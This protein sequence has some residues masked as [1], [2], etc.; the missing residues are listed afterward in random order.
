MTQ[1]I[2]VR[3]G[4]T[5]WNLQRRYQGQKDIPLNA[6]G[7]RQ[8]QT[9][10]ALLSHEVFDAIYSSDL[11][12]AL[13]T[14][15]ILLDGRGIPLVTD[16][17]L[18]EIGFGE[19]EGE[20][21]QEMFA[22][23][24]DRFAL[25]RNDPAVTMAPGGESVAQVAERTN[26]VAAEIARLYPSGRVLIVTHGMALATLVCRARGTVLSEAFNLVPDNAQPVYIEWKIATEGI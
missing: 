24:P 21:F 26:A 6:E 23:Y 17:R 11:Q 25:S 9:L 4:Q 8:A 10:A 14:A 12:R 1:L 16:T 5:D 20:L 15:Q 2:L 3:H 22:K 19:W 7:L 18:R 13:Q